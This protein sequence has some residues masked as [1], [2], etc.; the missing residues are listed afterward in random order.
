MQLQPEDLFALRTIVREELGFALN[1][2]AQT[3]LLPGM[4][5]APAEKYCRDLVA[6]EVATGLT[7]DLL[8]AVKKASLGQP[9]SPFRGHGAF[10]ADVRRWL[11][12]RPAFRA[13]SRR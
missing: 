3:P 13:P 4:E 1:R 11:D 2:P 10:P 9:D 12:A 5:S 7:Q 8:R 6:L